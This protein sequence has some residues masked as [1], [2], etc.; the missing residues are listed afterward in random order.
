MFGV[1]VQA[2]MYVLQAAVALLVGACVAVLPGRRGGTCGLLVTQPLT[3]WWVMGVFSSLL[4]GACVSW[5]EFGGC[6]GIESPRTVL[7]SCHLLCL[8]AM[9]S[10]VLAHVAAFTPCMLQPQGRL[11]SS[12]RLLL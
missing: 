11:H 5:S 6:A 4:P 2:V 1:T 12:L 9:R 3:V 10:C 8:A 7:L